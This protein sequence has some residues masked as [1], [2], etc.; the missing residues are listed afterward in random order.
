[1][2]VRGGSCPASFHLDN[3]VP[4]C[5]GIASVEVDAPGAAEMAKVGEKLGHGL[6][7]NRGLKAATKRGGFECGSRCGD[8]VRSKH[9]GYGFSHEVLLSFPV[10]VSTPQN[11]PGGE[12]R[13]SPQFT[14]ARCAPAV[15]KGNGNAVFRCGPPLT[16][17]RA[18]QSWR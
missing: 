12:A 18:R 10:E 17:A 5:G 13:L 16:A 8:A 2:V 9:A 3:E 14:A 11:L 4:V 7:G 15:N 1:M 6:V